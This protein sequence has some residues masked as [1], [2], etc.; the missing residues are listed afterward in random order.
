M[1][2]FYRLLRPS[3]LALLCMGADDLERGIEEDFPGVRMY[4]SHYDAGTNLK[5]IRECGFNINWSEI[6]ADNTSPGST[7]LFILAQKNC[8]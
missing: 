4:W 8:T 1:Q 7:Q 5:M 2:D 3:G 6:V